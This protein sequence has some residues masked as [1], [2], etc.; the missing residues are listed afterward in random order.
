MY[1][2]VE[3]GRLFNKAE[4]GITMR[5]RVSVILTISMLV[6]LVIFRVGNTSLIG[7]DP[8]MLDSPSI[9]LLS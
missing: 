5:E 1:N 9:G 7:A 3:D 2:E 6:V 4:G 8:L